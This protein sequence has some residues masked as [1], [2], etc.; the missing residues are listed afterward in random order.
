MPSA[1]HCS[2]KLYFESITVRE[3]TD[4]G[5]DTNLYYLSQL[6]MVIT[7]NSKNRKASPIHYV[8]WNSEGVVSSVLI[9]EIYAL[10]AW[11]DNFQITC[12]RKKDTCSYIYRF[13]INI[14]YDHEIITNFLKKIDD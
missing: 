11:Q 1:W 4:A 10:Y 8:S 12:Y 14:L 13:K 3:Y 9:A 6:S 7:L 5:F 2:P